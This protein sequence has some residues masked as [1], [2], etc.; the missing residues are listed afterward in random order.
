MPSAAIA[1]WTPSPGRHDAVT[2]PHAKE[3][4]APMAVP[5]IIDCD[6]GHD[7]VVAIWLAAGHPDI[8]L[9]AITT[10][11]GNGNLEHTTLNARVATTVAGIGGVPVSAGAAEPLLWW[12]GRGSPSPWSASTSRTRP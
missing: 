1:G 4:G 3:G 8:D 2:D 9:R 10:V 7:D 11:A 12:C 6:P 5:I